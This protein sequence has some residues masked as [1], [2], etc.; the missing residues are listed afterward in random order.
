MKVRIAFTEKERTKA[1]QLARAC[2]AFFP[3]NTMTKHSDLHKPFLHIYIA[4][5]NDGHD[6]PD[7]HSKRKGK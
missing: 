7:R 4:D 3:K 1:M 5:N 6:K 2:L